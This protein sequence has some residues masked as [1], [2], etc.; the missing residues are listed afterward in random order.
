MY[1]TDDDIREFVRVW[2]AEFGETIP[3]EEAQHRAALLLELFVLLA[4]TPPPPPQ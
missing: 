4:E 3:T 2:H 1:L